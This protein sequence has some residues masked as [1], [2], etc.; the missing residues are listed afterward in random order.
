MKIDPF[1]NLLR[2]GLFYCP[3]LSTA[4]GFVITRPERGRSWTRGNQKNDC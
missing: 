1:I 3:G 4:A 2:T